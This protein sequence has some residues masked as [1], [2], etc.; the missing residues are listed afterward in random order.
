ML[1]SLKCIIPLYIPPRVQGEVEAR[2]VTSALEGDIK[3]KLW[4]T[5]LIETLHKDNVAASLSMRQD[6]AAAALSMRQDNAAAALSMRQDN[7][8][9]AL[10]MRQENAAAALSIRQEL[11]QLSSVVENL[12]E[13]LDQWSITN[14]ASALIG[15]LKNAVSLQ[16]GISV[17]SIF[18]SIFLTS[19]LFPFLRA[20]WLP[21]P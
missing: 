12:K 6:N 7:A 18:L 3:F 1:P 15:F 19:Y 8:A 14:I 13:R 20:I 5:E 21:H 16:R 11:R 17:I 4:S 10:S 2:F 9:A